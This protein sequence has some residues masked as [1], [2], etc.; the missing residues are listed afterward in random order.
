MKDIEEN[1][2]FKKEGTVMETKIWKV[3]KSVE[4]LDSYPQILEA[5]DTIRQNELVSFPTETVYGLGANAKSDEAV[6]KIYE[7]KGRPSDNPLIIHISSIDSVAEFV[8]T[9]PPVAKIL[10][11]HFW[12]GPLTI[13]LKK[14]ENVISSLATVGLPTV[15]IRM[16]NHEIALALIKASGV[17][18]AAP[19][20]NTSG[21][22]SP[23]HFEHVYNDLNGK[24]AGIIDGGDSGVGV[25]STV[26]D[27]TGEVPVILRPGGVTKE[28][29]EK[30]VGKVEVDP[31]LH[32]KDEKPKSPGMKYKH[33]APNAPMYLVE[34]S[35]LFIQKLAWDYQQR[36]KKVGILTTDEQKHLY[37]A[38]TVISCGTRENLETVAHN[39]YHALRQF[40]VEKVDVIL[41]E[42]FPE[43]NIGFAIMN[44]L[45]KAAGNH[46]IHE[47]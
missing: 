42:S 31:S 32:S 3:D 30:L 39:L 20:A 7:A 6:K 25:E 24:I 28:D 29:I 13:I 38:D 2:F 33:Y 44:R 12:P 1:Y 45:K 14:K 40:D 19:S 8:E 35:Q 11:D 21:K 23:T 26:I 43:K 18:I 41:S 27:C 46:I 9:I 17:P 34:G 47:I 15:A 36:G 4:K 37:E 10:M 16:P 22:P 5:A